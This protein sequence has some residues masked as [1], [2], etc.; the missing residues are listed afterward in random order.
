[1][2]PIGFDTGRKGLVLC[3]VFSSCLYCNYCLSIMIMSVEPLYQT[4]NP[5]LKPSRSSV[6]LRRLITFLWWVS[7]GLL[8][9]FVLVF[10]GASLALL[11]VEPIKSTFSD[12]PPFTMLVSA[13]SMIVA[14]AAFL[15]ILKQLRMICQT[16]LDGDPFVPENAG[17]LRT[18]WIAVAVAEVLRLITGFFLSGIHNEANSNGE[19]LTLDLRVY[20]WFVVLALIVLAEVFREGTRLR[21]EQKLTV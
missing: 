11:E 12:V 13:L 7:W 14:A 15:I 10:I 4:D 17:R 20:V 2:L 5:A 3:A 6:F 21:Q 8:G 19:T 9:A 1:M 18:V 16:L